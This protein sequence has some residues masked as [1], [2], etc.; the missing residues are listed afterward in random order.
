ME[1]KSV[2]VTQGYNKMLFWWAKNQKD[3]ETILSIRKI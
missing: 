3:L 2:L 1:I